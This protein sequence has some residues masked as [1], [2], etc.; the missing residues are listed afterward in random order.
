MQA[1]QISNFS[2]VLSNEF[3]DVQ[4]T[5]EG[6]FAPIHAPYFLD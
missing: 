1:L 6:N 3:D 4:A 2:S 5:S